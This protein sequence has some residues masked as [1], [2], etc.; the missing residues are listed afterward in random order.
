MSPQGRCSPTS[1]LDGD[2]GKKLAKVSVPGSYEHWVTPIVAKGRLFVAG[3]TG[4]W[5][6]LP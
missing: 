4:A 2:T 3:D 6:F 1:A 5:A